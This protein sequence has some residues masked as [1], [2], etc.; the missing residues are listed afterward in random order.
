MGR[1]WGPRES[2]GRSPGRSPGP[3]CVVQGPRASTRARLGRF[4]PGP[5][6]GRSRG[7]REAKRADRGVAQARHWGTR[8]AGEALRDDAASP[9]AAVSGICREAIAPPCRAMIAPPCRAVRSS[10]AA[11]RLPLRA[12]LRSICDRPDRR[13]R[14]GGPDPPPQPAI[15]VEM[16]ALRIVPRGLAIGVVTI[17][18]A[19][20]GGA[21]ATSAAGHTGRRDSRGQPGGDPSSR[22]GRGQPAARRA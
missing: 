12:D 13:S 6:C 10:A 19:A 7:R 11:A 3:G 17:A 8:S 5:H 20:C 1:S 18:L 16:S 15:G 22:S 2:A 21:G 4:R 14:S 9:C